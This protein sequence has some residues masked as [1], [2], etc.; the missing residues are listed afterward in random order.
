[1]IIAIGRGRGASQWPDQEEPVIDD[2]EGLGFVPKVMLSSHVGSRLLRW[3]FGRLGRIGI[4][5]R[6]V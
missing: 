2:I 1:M 6:L 3:F 4:W 5:P